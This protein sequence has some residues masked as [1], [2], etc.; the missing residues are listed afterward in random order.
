MANNTRK[1]IINADKYVVV[2]LSLEE[3][4]AGGD[5]GK[6]TVQA[7][8]AGDFKGMEEVDSRSWEDGQVINIPCFLRVQK[9]KADE[10]KTAPRRSFEPVGAPEAAEDKPL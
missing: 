6:V 4:Q 5:A 9:R 3:A 10:A 7:F 2:Y 8:D 1:P